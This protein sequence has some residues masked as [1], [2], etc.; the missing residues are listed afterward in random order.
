VP[1]PQPNFHGREQWTLRWLLKK[2]QSEDV[3]S[4]AVAWRL[5]KSVVQRMPGP[6]TAGILNERKVMELLGKAVGEALRRVRVQK[7][8]KVLVEDSS[9]TV[10]GGTAISKSPSK[11]RKRSGEIVASSETQDNKEMKRSG[12]V[13][14]DVDVAVSIFEALRHLVSRMGD[15]KFVTGE[16]RDTAF[17]SEYMK[18][19]IR[20][21]SEENAKILGN[22][23]ELSGQI[24]DSENTTAR[25]KWLAPFITMWNTRKESGSDNA[26]FAKYCLA[27][28]LK[29][30][31]IRSIPN[32]WRRD[33]EMLLTRNII[34]PVKT[35]YLGSKDTEALKELIRGPIS[36]NP[37]FA[38]DILNISIRCLQPGVSRRLRL[39][40]EAWL[41]AVFEVLMDSISTDALVKGDTVNAMLQIFIQDKVAV[42]QTLLTKIAHECGLPKDIAG[43][44][45]IHGS[46]L[47]SMIK[48]DPQ[49]F[50]LSSEEDGSLLQDIFSKITVLSTTSIWPE[51][52]DLY[53]DGIIV[54]IMAAFAKQRNLI[55]FFKEWYGQL[56]QLEEL[57]AKAKYDIPHFSAWEDEALH[58]KLKE[59]MEAS[60]TERQI[61][62]IADFIGLLMWGEKP[63]PIFVLADAFTGAIK[64]EQNML[65]DNIAVRIFKRAI[66]YARDDNVP[67][68]YQYHIP[69][70]MTHTFD[71]L[72]TEDYEVFGK[73]KSSK[74]GFI[75]EHRQKMFDDFET[76]QDLQRL[77]IVRQKVVVMRTFS[78]IA[79]QKQED[80]NHI[81][82]AILSGLGACLKGVI[83]GLASGAELGDEVWGKRIT[84]IHR[85]L[86]WF[87]CEYSTIL[88][89]EYS[90]FLLLVLPYSSKDYG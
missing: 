14:T 89:C 37:R 50:V 26:I 57:R 19:V 70:V 49:V 77:E 54:P 47:A 85:G 55:A 71:Y 36:E 87:A 23:L 67:R 13:E 62:D 16:G 17:F 68:H 79:F 35:A 65:A 31:S 46:L 12:E 6:S 15:A 21:E 78:H 72:Q 24:I 84:S 32:P 60:L 83:K 88:F 1:S 11:K 61:I 80:I 40:D 30:F 51:V 66:K 9:D 53:V 45:S 52:A 33:L 69:R 82:S 58:V 76:I 20:G 18:S 90:E 25:K 44:Q 39:E 34:M 2:L 27:P 7:G 43:R 59:V 28:A 41:Q 64:K 3:R 29:L 48:L 86:G 81:A 42:E 63:G 10:M 4:E 5:F 75:D 38:P 8:E 74:L 22:W 73:N 56:E